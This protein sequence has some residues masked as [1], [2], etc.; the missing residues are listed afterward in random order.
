M[1]SGITDTATATLVTASSNGKDE[2]SQN[3]ALIQ[4]TR[5]GA[6]IFTPPLSGVLFE[7][8]NVPN[9]WP[10]AGSLPYMTVASLLLMLSPLPLILKV[11]FFVAQPSRALNARVRACRL[12][13]AACLQDCRKQVGLC[14]CLAQLADNK[15]GKGLRLLHS[16]RSKMEADM[17]V[18]MH[19]STMRG[20]SRGLRMSDA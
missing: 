1:C 15:P 14:D 3:L 8:S 7:Y 9:W 6:R 4:S 20:S 11:C 12:R 19:R 13:F 2:R 18:H 16:L 5:A 10:A 17:H